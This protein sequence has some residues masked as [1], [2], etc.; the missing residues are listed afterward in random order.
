MRLTTITP[1]LCELSGELEA[2]PAPT[3]ERKQAAREVMGLV[4]AGLFLLESHD[5]ANPKELMSFVTKAKNDVARFAPVLGEHDPAVVIVREMVALVLGEALPPQPEPVHDAGP[6][7]A[8]GDEP[9]PRGAGVCAFPGDFRPLLHA[10]LSRIDGSTWELRRTTD[11]LL[12]QCAEILLAHVRRLPPERA[13]AA[14]AVLAE[15]LMLDPE[16]AAARAA[17]S[18]AVRPPAAAELA[19]HYAGRTSHE[20]SY[21]AGPIIADEILPHLGLARIDASGA[22]LHTLQEFSSLDLHAVAEFILVGSGDMRDYRKARGGRL[23][24]RCGD[25]SEPRERDCRRCGPDPRP[26]GLTAGGASAISRA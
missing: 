12:L 5:D 23:C 25:Y 3:D 24:R 9:E 26:G 4:A 21:V 10:D 18:P 13:W 2:L 16:E 6:D 11:W 8:F 14:Y 17:G 20:H 22:M 15:K 1:R 7:G 19:R